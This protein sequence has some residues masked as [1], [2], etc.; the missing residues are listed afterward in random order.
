MHTLKV[1]VRVIAAWALVSLLAA[2]GGG[3]GGGANGISSAISPARNL[4]GTWIAPSAPTIYYTENNC[5]NATT[6]SMYTANPSATSVW[7]SLNMVITPGIDV[8]H[9][10]VAVDGTY[11]N[12]TKIDANCPGPVTPNSIVAT[13]YGT[14]SSSNLILFSDGYDG[15]S[16]AGNFNFTTNIMT[17]TWNESFTGTGIIAMYSK[18]SAI[19]LTLQ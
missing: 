9:V 16:Q 1:V 19:T 4:I 12:G 7:A 2:C 10:L 14:I 18:P 5:F 13:Y 6:Q 17:G 8:N 11:S 15:H 3:G